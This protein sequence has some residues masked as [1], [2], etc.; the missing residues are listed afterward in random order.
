ML[1]STYTIC[2][3][4]Q[5]WVVEQD[6]SPPADS[7]KGVARIWVK[8]A[9]FPV[10]ESPALVRSPVREKRAERVVGAGR[11]NPARACRPVNGERSARPVPPVRHRGCLLAPFPCAWAR[12]SPPVLTC[13]S[14][15][16]VC[17]L[18]QRC[19]GVLVGWGS[20]WGCGVPCC[21]LHRFLRG[22]ICIF[23]VEF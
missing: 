12:C 1:Q 23:T 15:S 9:G 2:Q 17:R 19:A 21:C 5:S 3:C 13:Q 18:P 10:R 16:S 8:P 20:V 7:L 22:C 6:C 14:E 11:V 4:H